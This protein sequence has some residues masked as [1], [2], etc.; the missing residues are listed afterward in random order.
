MIRR[1]TLLDKFEK[2]ATPFGLILKPGESHSFNFSELVSFSRIGTFNVTA[3]AD[4]V[5][6]P[7]KRISLFNN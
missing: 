3:I 6:E 2:S 5:K 4:I 7:S 1:V